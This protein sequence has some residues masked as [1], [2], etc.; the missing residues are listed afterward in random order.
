MSC[1]NAL[2]FGGYGK[3]VISYQ[4]PSG[5]Q[6]SEHP[7]TG[8]RYQGTSRTSYLP[9]SHKGREVLQFFRRA[10]DARLVFTV[11]TSNTTGLSKSSDM[12]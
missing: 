11:G 3:I 5:V 1:L 4:F 6:G 7:N 10:F 9:D 8:Q 2:L 12:E